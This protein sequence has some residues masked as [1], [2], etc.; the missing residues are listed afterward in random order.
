M[1]VDSHLY[2]SNRWGLED[3]KDIIENHFETKVNIRFCEYTPSM[4]I[5][6]FDYEGNPFSMYIHQQT[7][8]PLGRFTMLSAHAYSSTHKIF[9]ILGSIMGGL[10]EKEDSNGTMQFI[11][12]KIRDEDG[13][14]YHLKYAVFVNK[15]EGDDLEGLTESINNWNKGKR[16]HK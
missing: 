4:I 10:Y 13:L 2:L 15:I 16:L 5:F 8:T 12:G 11:Y 9:N 14:Q 7:S 6:S 1:G 3:L